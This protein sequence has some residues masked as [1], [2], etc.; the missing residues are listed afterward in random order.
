MGRGRDLAR[1]M[2]GTVTAGPT[3]NFAEIWTLKDHAIEFQA[4]PAHKRTRHDRR[5]VVIVQ[6]A[7]QTHK[8]RLSTI[9]VAPCSHQ[10]KASNSLAVVVE[11][12]QAGFPK[13][14]AVLVDICQPV[15]V[16]HF[17]ERKGTLTAHQATVLRRTLARLHGLAPGE[18][19]PRVTGLGPPTAS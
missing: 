16:Q 14:T 1:R 13:K 11:P 9:Q 3:P 6:P 2:A 15:A 5:F 12:C 10:W 17:L 8:N 19:D 7:K 4:A 18:P